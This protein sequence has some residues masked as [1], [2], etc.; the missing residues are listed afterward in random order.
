[1]RVPAW[2]LFAVLLFGV[3]LGWVTNGWRLEG[4][5]AGMQRD[6]ATATAAHTT[7]TLTHER[8]TNHDAHAADAGPAAAQQAQQAQARVITKEI[9]R[10]VQ[11]PAASVC[12]LPAEWV[13]I[14]DAAAAGVPADPGATGLPAAPPGAAPA[15]VPSGEALSGITGNYDTCHQEMNRIAG[16]QAWWNSVRPPQ[17]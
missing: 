6:A 11:S 4:E 7:A 12:P 1:M 5:I 2:G 14:H 9:V 16:W 8:Q 13:Q 3:F 10:Y 15:P 17:P